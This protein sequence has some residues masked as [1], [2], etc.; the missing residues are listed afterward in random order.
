MLVA[1][2]ADNPVAF[3][4]TQVEVVAG[5]KPLAHRATHTLAVAAAH[6]PRLEDT[7]ALK[8]ALDDQMDSPKATQVL[9]WDQWSWFLLLR[10]GTYREPTAMRVDLTRGSWRTVSISQPEG[11][12]WRLKA[13]A[14]QAEVKMRYAGG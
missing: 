10:I 3:H 4:R 14:G 12:H 6:S 1:A 2:E 9:H 8:T 5:D 7:P 13:L 11:V